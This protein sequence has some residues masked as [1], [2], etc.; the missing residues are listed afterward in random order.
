VPADILECEVC[1]HRYLS[2]VIKDEFIKYNYSVAESEYYDTVKSNPHDRQ[3][4]D[5]KKFAELIRSKCK[6]CST[7]LE[8]GSGMG[9]LLCELKK[10]GFKCTGID[11]SNFATSYARQELGLNVVTGILDEKTFLGKK[12]DIIILS[13]VVEH[14]YDINALLTLVTS[15]LSVD[16]RVV[17]LTGNSNS[18]YAKFC[19]KKW[20]YFFSWEHVSFFNRSSVQYLFKKHFLQLEYFKAKQHSG[21]FPQNLKSL[22]LT[23]QSALAN[24]LHLRNH[25]F[26]YYMA[27]DHFIAIGKNKKN[28]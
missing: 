9:Y 4:E 17:I 18:L 8:I 14:I 16:G 3:A 23:L 27:F 24:L 19:G 15:Y 20:L 7:I 11:P 26:Y 13:D 1:G 2:M 21:S 28:G 22:Y 12:F 6:D 10:R 25:T 5:T